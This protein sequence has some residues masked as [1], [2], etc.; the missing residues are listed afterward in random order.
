MPQ[1]YINL[2]EDHS[3]WSRLFILSTFGVWIG[4]FSV[5]DQIPHGGRILMGIL[6][7]A[8]IPVLWM[9]VKRKLVSIDFTKGIIIIR[10]GVVFLYKTEVVPLSKYDQIC[11]EKKL[12]YL[13][14]HDTKVSRIFYVTNSKKTDKYELCIRCY[15]E[16][17]LETKAEIDALEKV[18]VDSMSSY[19]EKL[20]AN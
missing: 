2:K 6:S 18:L 17:D 14:D 7:I 4:F 19:S 16:S 3:I 8:F 20:T 9:V 12:D 5:W 11:V 1:D 15:L 13:D 10:K